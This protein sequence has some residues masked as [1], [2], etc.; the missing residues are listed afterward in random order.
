MSTATATKEK[1][2]QVYTIHSLDEVEINTRL[3]AHPALDETEARTLT[4]QIQKTSQRL[5][6]LVTEAHDRKAHA[7]LG[8]ET[9]ADYV[10]GEL[11]MS[12]SR[13]Y[14]LLDAGHVMKAL[15]G[16][17]VDIEASPTPPV[18]VINRIKNRL[19][20]VKKVA[21]DALKKG[22]SVDAALREL[23]REPVKRSRAEVA[24]ASSAGGSGGTVAAIGKGGEDTSS[25]APNKKVSC[26]ACAG[27]G[28]VTKSVSDRLLA[29]IAKI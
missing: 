16:A 5:W 7:A 14:Q 19:T 26:P 13:S 28:K 23:S 24:A 2:G 21:S 15:A 18:R 3:R 6:L 9:W 20:D 10:K 17:G 1:T 11:H 27:S 12:E 4:T 29:V 22:E 25:V 8:Y